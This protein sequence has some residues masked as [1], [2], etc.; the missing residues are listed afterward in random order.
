MVF[1]NKLLHINAQKHSEYIST[2]EQPLEGGSITLLMPRST[3]NTLEDRCVSTALKGAIWE[4]NWHNL[5]VLIWPVYFTS[6]K[7]QW[8]T[9]EKEG[10]LCFVGHIE[11]WAAHTFKTPN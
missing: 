1:P 9:Y 10:I 7:T 8:D 6:I 5:L 4:I 11:Y 3:L 2:S